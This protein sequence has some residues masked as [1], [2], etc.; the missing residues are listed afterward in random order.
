MHRDEESGSQPVAE[1]VWDAK[2]CEGKRE[3]KGGVSKAWD[4][5]VVLFS[6][7]EP[8]EAGW[9]QEVETRLLAS[10]LTRHFAR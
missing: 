6:E 4:K 1:V 10:N 8:G 3:Q 5:L 7:V 9:G 2:V